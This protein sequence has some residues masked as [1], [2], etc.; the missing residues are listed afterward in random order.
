M[1]KVAFYAS[2]TANES[3]LCICIPIGIG[4]QVPYWMKKGISCYNLTT[5]SGQVKCA[6][7]ESDWYARGIWLSP[8]KSHVQVGRVILPIC[9]DKKYEQFRSYSAKIFNLRRLH[10][11]ISVDQAVGGIVLVLILHLLTQRRSSI[12]P[13][14]P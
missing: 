2:P 4:R 8:V 10:M 13:F 14:N 12:Q 5:E 6:Q 11:R 9:E 7:S 1:V 3:V